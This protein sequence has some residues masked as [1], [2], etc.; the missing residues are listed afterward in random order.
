MFVFCFARVRRQF[1][2]VRPCD[3]S[4]GTVSLGGSISV[5]LC[6][7][8]TYSPLLPTSSLLTYLLTCVRVYLYIPR[9]RF[10]RFVFKGKEYEYDRVP[11]AVWAW[12]LPAVIFMPHRLG[13][14][15]K[16]DSTAITF[17]VRA[18][19]VVLTGWHIFT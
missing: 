1:W 18:L 17:A 15:D 7:N 19:S 4:D 3:T 13:Y 11:T 16:V 2:A 14:D 5:L 10:F 6:E 9:A 8:Y 12:A